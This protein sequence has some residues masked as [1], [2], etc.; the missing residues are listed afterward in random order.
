LADD[1]ASPNT[2]PI[3]TTDDA[4]SKACS[5]HL[6]NVEQVRLVDGQDVSIVPMQYGEIDAEWPAFTDPF[7]DWPSQQ[8]ADF[9]LPHLDSQLM[10]G[11]SPLEEL[12]GLFAG[13]NDLPVDF[14]SNLTSDHQTSQ[15]AVQQNSPISLKVNRPVLQATRHQK[16]PSPIR[17]S[18]EMREGFLK[19]LSDQVAPELLKLM[20]SFATVLYER[21]LQ[22]YFAIFNT[23]SPLFHLPSL[24]ID[25]IPA[26]LF[27]CMCAIGAIYRM[28]RKIAAIFYNAAHQSLE[29]ISSLSSGRGPP[30]LGLLLQDWIKPAGLK[31]SQSS[32]PQLWISQT[33]LLLAMFESF[34]GDPELSKMAIHRVGFFVWVSSRVP[35]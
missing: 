12:S 28:E 24:D 14:V 7:F 4:S 1:N 26:P 31:N 35:P 2:N 34:S 8:M 11:F 5:V 20:T 30:L 18:N 19:D 27:L 23:H 17:L 25:K 6:Y 29:T 22:R 16:P 13:S 15:S 3:T 33:K 9:A 10:D 32:I 21:C